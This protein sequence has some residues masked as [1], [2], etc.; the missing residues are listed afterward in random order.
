L[1]NKTWIK[2]A[3]L[4]LLIALVG[5]VGY[6]AYQRGGLGFRMPDQQEFSDYFENNPPTLNYS[7]RNKIFEK[8]REECNFYDLKN[9][10]EGRPST[11][12]RPSIDRA[13]YTTS[14]S[15][16]IFL[17]GDSHVE[18]LYY[19]LKTK[20]PSDISILQVASSGCAAQI[21]DRN[22]AEAEYCR[23]SNDFAIS[24][25]KNTAPQIVILAQHSAHDERNDLQAIAAFLKSIGVS[26]VIVV[27]PVPKWEP[28]LY[29]LIIKKFWLSTPRRT[30]QNIDPEIF[31]ADQI[32]KEKYNSNAGGFQYISMIDF[33]CNQEGCLTYIG[34]DRREGI[35]T[36]DY[37]H[38]T[39][40]ASVYV[41]EKLLAPEILKSIQR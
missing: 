17:W 7:K 36:F 25:I 35:V 15:T 1:G 34:E 11:V 33:F 27:G 4:C 30:F 40:N 24:A 6:N 2:T 12:P 16:S 5:Y 10:M 26:K 41:A 31:R 32:L 23:K 13:C 39:P 37:G 19:G 29:K 38:L 20:L 22:S 3:T 9:W 21:G 14:S 28:S 18:Q 8:F